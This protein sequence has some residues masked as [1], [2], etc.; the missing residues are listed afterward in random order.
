M[1]K[2]I[3]SYAF[4]L[5]LVAAAL[6]C[7]SQTAFAQSVGPY[8]SVKLTWKVLPLIQLTIT[9]NYQT[10]F[11]PQGGS[12][13]GSTP[14]PGPG[15]VLNGGV[16]DFG[17]QVVQGFSYLYKFAAQAKVTSND[18]SGFTVYAEGSSDI[19]DTTV[20]G[21]IPLNQTL[22]WLPSNSA[23]GP[24]STATA[25]QPTTSPVGCTGTCINYVGNP[26]ST[27]IV[28]NYPSS[29]LGQP[30]NAVTQG[31]DYQLRLFNSPNA[32]SYQ[33]NIVYTAVGN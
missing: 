24:F 33:V 32:D 8:G 19:Q 1:G 10:G 12:G 4:G 23:N 31:W 3:R 22:F 11:G 5:A 13:S 2:Q 9:P 14:A 28:W 25:F 21:T 30:G 27:A 7:L 18:A 6:V 15:A 29:T 16:V 20:A 17:N 26:P